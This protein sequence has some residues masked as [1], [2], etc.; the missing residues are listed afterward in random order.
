MIMIEIGGPPQVS[1]SVSW[2]CLKL[3]CREGSRCLVGRGPM[4]L[5]SALQ[6]AIMQAMRMCCS[7]ESGC[8][9]YRRQA[10]HAAGRP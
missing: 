3:H 4:L 2:S 6:L 10:G 7:M 1:F 8:T 9:T 5:G